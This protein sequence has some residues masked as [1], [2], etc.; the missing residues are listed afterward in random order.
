[1]VTPVVYPIQRLKKLALALA[2]ASLAGCGSPDLFSS[3]SRSSSGLD[4]G[5]GGSYGGYGGGGY[6][7]NGGLNSRLAGGGQA[8]GL[9]GRGTYPKVELSFELPDVKGNP[10]DYAENDVLVTITTP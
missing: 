9:R 7:G 1:M 5:L 10:F 6:G 4:G 2:A 3:G 8:P